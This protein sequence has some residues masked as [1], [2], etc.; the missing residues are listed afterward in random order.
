MAISSSESDIVFSSCLQEGLRQSHDVIQRWCS[1]LVDLLYERSRVQP[2][3]AQRRSLQNAVGALKEHRAFIES[4]FAEQL[5]IAVHEDMRQGTA[6]LSHSP[7]RS[8]SALSFDQLELM[9]DN[10]V[11]KAVE[12]ARL[13]QVIKLASEAGLA[14]F[15]ARLSTAQGFQMVKADKNP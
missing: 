8:F 14:G 3:P 4:G 7:E 10:Q 12:A 15:S 5:A 13:H 9:G 11:Q 1:R 2:D 6:R